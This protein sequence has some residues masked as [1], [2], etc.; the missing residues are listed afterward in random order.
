MKSILHPCTIFSASPLSRFVY[1]FFQ[2]ASF[3]LWLR[4]LCVSW[5]WCLWSSSSSSKKIHISK[6]NCKY[7]RL[8]AEFRHIKSIKRC[9]LDAWNLRNISCIFYDSLASISSRSLHPTQSLL[10]ALSSQ[11]LK[12]IES[13]FFLVLFSFAFP[14]RFSVY[15]GGREKKGEAQSFI[16]LKSIN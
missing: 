7:Y 8:A 3:I 11:T 10:L 12:F 6:P 16:H 5:E 4:F 13:F 14:T 9:F 15:V 2:Y 1:I